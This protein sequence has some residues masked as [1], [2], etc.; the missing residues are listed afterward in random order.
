VVLLKAC[1]YGIFPFEPLFALLLNSLLVVELVVILHLN[2]LALH[3]LLHTS[4][5]LLLLHLQDV[6]SESF[7]LEP[8][9]F[10]LGFFGTPLVAS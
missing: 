10:P 1:I 8:L 5:S 4:L 7:L 2:A 6:L 9:R 3:L